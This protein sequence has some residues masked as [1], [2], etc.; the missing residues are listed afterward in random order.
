M[1]MIFRGGNG[2]SA[3]TAGRNLALIMFMPAVAMGIPASPATAAG[4]R[5][6]AATF[7]LLA[8]EH[9]LEAYLLQR[10]LVPGAAKET[11]RTLRGLEGSAQLDADRLAQ[12]MGKVVLH[13]PVED[14]RDVGVQLLL[15]LEELQLAMLPWTGLEH[16]EDEDILT[17]VVG[18]GVEHS[19]ALDSGSRRRAV[20]AGQ[21][22]ADGNHT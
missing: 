1:A 11:K 7:L 21:I 4:G 14:E 16:G 8:D 15:Q 12:E 18:K 22:F 17:G 13:L 3:A 2:S 19:G 20:P 6:A 10:E 9:D 5:S